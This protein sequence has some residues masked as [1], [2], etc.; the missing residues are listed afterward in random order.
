MNETLHTL[1]VHVIATIFAFSKA[2]QPASAAR[3]AAELELPESVI[4]ET[5]ARLDRA[6]LV[7]GRRVRL[8]LLGLALAV[9][10]TSSGRRAIYRAAA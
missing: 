3:L 2:G 10:A 6:E 7:D 4:E 5:L 1:N 8:T 9:G